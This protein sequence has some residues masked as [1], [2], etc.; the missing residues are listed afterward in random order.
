ME[1][2]SRNLPDKGRTTYE[3]AGQSIT[4]SYDIVRNT[5]VKGNGKVSDA[6]IVAFITLCKYNKLNPFLNEAYLIKFGDSPAQL[7]VG[8]DTYFKRADACLNYDG[9]QSGI[10]ISRNGQ[11]ID[12]EGCFF[13]S[14]NEILLGGWAKVFRS[15]RKYPYVQRLSLSEYDKKQSIWNDKKATMICKIAKVHA[16]REAFPAQLGAMYTD[17]EMPQQQPELRVEEEIK[18]EANKQIIDLDRE[19]GEVVFAK[20]E[21]VQQSQAPF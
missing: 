5:L 9:M 10:I 6:E 19:S 16:L 21:E 17:Y 15:D 4:L 20:T 3:V 11:I 2:N 8:Q 14:K 18:E 13:D 7:V 1:I 12:V